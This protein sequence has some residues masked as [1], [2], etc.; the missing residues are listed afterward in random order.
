MAHEFLETIEKE[1]QE[2]QE[3]LDKIENTSSGAVKTKEDLFMKLKRELIPHMKAEEKAFYPVLMNNGGKEVGLEAIE[4]HH[5]AE[6]VL[7]EL[8]KLPKNAENWDAKF[9]VFAELLKH[10]IEEEEEDVFDAAEDMLDDDQMSQVMTSFME[11]K[12][13][14]VKKLK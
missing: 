11:E 14:I 10:H 7:K 1:H 8:D 9:K 6:I 4:E 13:S 3:L 2:V 12:K 5:V